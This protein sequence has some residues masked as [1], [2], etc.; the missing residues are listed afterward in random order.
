MQEQNL[1][2][3]RER[4]TRTNG[5]ARNGSSPPSSPP[6]R[7]AARASSRWSRAVVR[8]VENGIERIDGRLGA[9][10]EKVVVD[11]LSREALE[12][13]DVSLRVWE[14]STGDLCFL[15][16]VEKRDVAGEGGRARWRWW[17]TL[18]RTPA[19]LREEL[20]SGLAARRRRLIA[21]SALH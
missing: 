6:S 9:A 10:F 15:C 18:L 19:Q 11:L 17:S 2:H 13:V 20:R 4:E 16:R 21:P 8:V 5:P 12:P 3:R 7:A 1:T 14:P